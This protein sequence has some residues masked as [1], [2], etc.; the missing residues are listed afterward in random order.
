LLPLTNHLIFPNLS[1]PICPVQLR[2]GGAQRL[3]LSTGL[4]HSRCWI[5]HH[6]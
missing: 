5:Q 4:R 3:E 6:M 1:F 2:W